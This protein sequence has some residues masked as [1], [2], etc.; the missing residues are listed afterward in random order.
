MITFPIKETVEELI[1]LEK[2]NPL[3]VTRLRWLRALKTNPSA[4]PD[5]LAD[6]F[7]TTVVEM[8]RWA[9]LYQYGGITML[10]NPLTLLERSA[11]LGMTFSEHAEKKML[12]LFVNHP[13][14]YGRRLWLDFE[15]CKAGTPTKSYTDCSLFA[16][17][18]DFAAEFGNMTKWTRTDCISY[19]QNVIRYALEKTGRRADYKTINFAYGTKMAKN[20]VALGWRAYLLMPDAVN[21]Y[22]KNADHTKKYQTAVKTKKWWEVPLT[23]IIVNYK[24]TTVYED[25]T[26]VAAP[27]VLDSAATRK[28]GALANV[29]FAAGVFTNG[30]HTAI[31]AR[32]KILEVHWRNVSEQNTTVPGQYQVFQSSPNASLYQA[33]N[34]IDFDWLEILLVVPP[35]SSVVV[36]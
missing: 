34:V 35:D 19:L 7:G 8:E 20:L 30:I 22:D 27:T 36:R 10:L 12:E 6:K 21:P 17:Y 32:G 13:N 24:P 4:T 26:T 28:L 5:S 18:N 14:E 9:L 15:A 11:A 29:K 25:G 1:S 3:M 16:N 2:D 23:D 31:F 33:T